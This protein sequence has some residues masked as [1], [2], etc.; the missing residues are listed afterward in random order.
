[1]EK[2]LTGLALRVALINISNLPKCNFIA[3]DEG[4]A[5]MDAENISSVSALFSILKEHFEFIWI[6]SHLDSM[7]D[8]VNI[9]LEIVKEN[10]FSKINYM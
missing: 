8:F 4:W 9:R 3:I 7:R 2:F 1:M 5:T 6:I 10:G